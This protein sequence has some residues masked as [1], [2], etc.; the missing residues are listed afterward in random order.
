MEPYMF[1]NNINT[2]K[3]ELTQASVPVFVSLYI[4]ICISLFLFCLDHNLIQMPDIIY[5]FL[6]RSV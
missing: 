2:Q 6:D 5:I 4:H 3:Q 1:L